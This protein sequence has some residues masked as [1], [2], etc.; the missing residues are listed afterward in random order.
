MYWWDLAA[1]LVRRGAVRRSGLVTTT[2][3]TQTFNRRVLQG[4]MEADDPVSIVFA[5]SDHPWATW[6]YGTAKGGGAEVASQ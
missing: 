1:E 6:K 4:H 3:I 2:S 5:T